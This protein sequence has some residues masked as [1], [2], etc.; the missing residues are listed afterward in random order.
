[1]SGMD[2]IAL[3]V[4][5][6]GLRAACDEMGATLIR[7][8]FSPN[9]KERH[10]CSTALFDSA[11]ELVMQAEHIPVHL[12]SMPDAVAAVLEEEQRPGDLWILNDPY[13]GGTHLP[14]ITLIAPVFADAG[15][16]GF[17]ASRAHHADV[18]GP[19]PGGMPADSR[20]LSDEGIVIPPTRLYPERIGALAAE[21]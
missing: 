15:L 14:D 21:M 16:L 13:R 8:A 6:G 17:A 19:T 5:V 1:M 4:L 18:G 12:G 7:A 2:P 11:G 20:T 9:I 10:D 3:Q